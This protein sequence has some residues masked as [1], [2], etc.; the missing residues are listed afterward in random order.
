MSEPGDFAQSLFDGG[1]N[2][3]ESTIFSL[4]QF[5]GVDSEMIPRIATGFGGGFSR[6]KNICGAV[7]GAIMGL[8]L[9]F[10]RDDPRGNKETCYKKTQEFIDSFLSRFGSLKCFELSGVDFNTSEGLKLYKE[11]VHRECCVKLVRFAVEKVISMRE[12]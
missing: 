6:T 11:K 5:L 12:G 1:M 10:G 7:T 2:C 3:A 9:I 4:S 8:G